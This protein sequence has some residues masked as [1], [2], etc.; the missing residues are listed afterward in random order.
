M[1]K[2]GCLYFVVKIFSE[3][4][5]SMENF[6]SIKMGYIIENLTGSIRTSMLDSSTPCETSLN[7]LFPSLW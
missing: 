4:D 5:L 2:D 7:C 1:S 6:D 3:L